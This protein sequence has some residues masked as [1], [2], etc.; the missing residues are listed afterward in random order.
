LFLLVSAA[1][2]TGLSFITY[3]GEELDTD[4][5]WLGTKFQI[6]LYNK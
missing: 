3:I 6:Q 2:K 4:N 5:D 1:L